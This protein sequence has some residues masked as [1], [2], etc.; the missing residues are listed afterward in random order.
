MSSSSSKDELKQVSSFFSSLHK[1]WVCKALRAGKHVVVEK[2]VALC[3]E[4]YQEMLDV[5]HETGKFLMDG[6]MYPH[7]SRTPDVVACARDEAHVG[8]VDR[9]ETAFSFLGD[10]SFFKNDIR[11]KKDGDPLGCLGDL[12]WYCIMMALLVFPTKPVSARVVDFK[13]TNEGVPIRASC[14][15]HFEGDC[16]LAF[17]CGFL[18]PLRQSVEICGSKKS[19]KMDDYVLPKEGPLQYELHSMSLTDTDLITIHDK[20]VVVCEA[21]PVQEVMLWQKFA[22]LATAVGAG[23]SE[24][25]GEGDEVVEAIKIAQMSLTAQQILN[26]LMNSIHHQAE[27]SV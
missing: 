26:A 24:W 2:P 25:S 17:H 4:D 10:E 15:V 6:T 19:I 20:E 13:L 21:G 3:V 27:V 14:L 16:V 23:S 1:E 9:I 22:K 8:K 7:H 18:T 12:G 11:T 5:A